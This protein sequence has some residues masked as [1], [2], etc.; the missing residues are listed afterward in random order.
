MTFQL[1]LLYH[2]HSIRLL[3]TITQLN[4]YQNYSPSQVLRLVGHLDNENLKANPNNESNAYIQLIVQ[5]NDHSNLQISH[6]LNECNNKEQTD[7]KEPSTE[8]LKHDHYLLLHSVIIPSS[9]CFTNTANKLSIARFHYGN[10]STCNQT[11]PLG[12]YG[13]MNQSDGRL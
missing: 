3:Q 6:D 5:A 13:S 12:S 1:S 7:S 11:I 2:S 8:D 4:P 9:I 10:H